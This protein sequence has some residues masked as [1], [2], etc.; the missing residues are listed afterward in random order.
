MPIEYPVAPPLD[1]PD[2][3][4]PGTAAA[5]QLSVPHTYLWAV[6][7]QGTAAVLLARAI[8]G[9]AAEIL[10]L[11]TRPQNRRQGHA[12]E[13][14]KTLLATANQSKCP[15]VFLEVRAANAAAR[16]LYAGLDFTEVSRR[17]GYYKNPTEDA[18]VL[19]REI[20]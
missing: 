18:I 7:Q 1:W 9:E 2:P 19:R 14:L 10:T 4:F 20:G 6:P 12:R 3:T 11:F 15:A 16:K 13:L 17:K 8:P 5:Q